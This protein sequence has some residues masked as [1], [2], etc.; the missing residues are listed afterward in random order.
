MP[1]VP[2][3]PSAPVRAPTISDHARALATGIRD[4]ADAMT[5]VQG[6]RDVL[7][8]GFGA[9]TSEALAA[10]IPEKPDEP[11]SGYIIEPIAEGFGYRT[12]K[13]EVDDYGSPIEPPPEGFLD[14]ATNLF[15]G[16]PK[17]QE[18]TMKGVLGLGKIIT[19]TG[20]KIAEKIAGVPTP[21]IGAGGSPSPPDDDNFE[22]S[23]FPEE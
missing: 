10:V 9:G 17:L 7:D 3:T 13:Q 1:A 19:T 20:T 11:T 18:M 12:R 5:Q 22:G 2:V 23:G 15:I 16:S 21:A 4:I 6:I 14:K 8:Q